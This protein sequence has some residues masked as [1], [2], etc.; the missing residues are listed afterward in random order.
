MCNWSALGSL[1]VLGINESDGN[2]GRP[3]AIHRPPFSRGCCS[4][5]SASRCN[6]KQGYGCA[7]SPGARLW[8]PQPLGPL[9]EEECE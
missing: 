5:G 8:R 1:R 9:I 3:A 7:P 2:Y 6:G 4:S